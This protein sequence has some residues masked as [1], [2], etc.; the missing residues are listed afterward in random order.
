MNNCFRF[1]VTRRS[2]AKLLLALCFGPVFAGDRGERKH[3]PKAGR[4]HT[5]KMESSA[6]YLSLDEVVD[7][8][9]SQTEGRI[10]S[11]E[12]TD[13]GYR[14]RVLTGDGKVRRFRI[15]PDTGKTIKRHR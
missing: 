15:D 6:G 1:K 3:N 2:A 7:R 9:R 13:S 12:E 14:I 10:L 11:A 5:M 4:R 8:L